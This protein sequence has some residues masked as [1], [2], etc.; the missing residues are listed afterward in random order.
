MAKKENFMSDSFPIFTYVDIPYVFIDEN[1]NSNSTILKKA[2]D[3]FNHYINFL[4]L[5]SKDD[6]ISI[7]LFKTL[8]IVSD[9]KLNKKISLSVNSILVSLLYNLNSLETDTNFDENKLIESLKEKNKKLKE[10]TTEEELKKEYPYLY[11]KSF[12]ESKNTI[13]TYIQLAKTK[14][15][16]IEIF[17]KMNRKQ[18]KKLKDYYKND[19][20]VLYL[21]DYYPY[22]EKLVLYT[23]N[24][25]KFTEAYSSFFERVINSIDLIRNHLK[26]YS[27]MI[28]D[29]S[30]E[31][32]L[33][34]ELLVAITIMKNS[35]LEN[36]IDDTKILYIKEF[37]KMNKDKY[38]KDFKVKI[39]EVINHNFV[40]AAKEITDVD[41]KYYTIE[42]LEKAYNDIVSKKPYLKQFENN[43][44]YKNNSK[45]EIKNM[46]YSQLEQLKNNYEEVTEEEI[47]NTLSD[48]I[49]NNKGDNNDLLKNKIASLIRKVDFLSG[50]NSTTIKPV[51]F[52]KGKGTFNNYFGYVYENGYVAFDYISKNVEK[53]YGHAIYII[54]LEDL[55]KYSNLS[56]DE[57]R[58]LHKDKV[59]RVV[60]RG[61]WEEKVHRYISSF[62]DIEQIIIPEEINR[63]DLVTTI[64]DFLKLKDDLELINEEIEKKLSEKREKLFEESKKI[65]EE[66]KSVQNETSS[67][68]YPSEVEELSDS[69]L[70]LL[71]LANGIDDFNKLYELSKNQ[72]RKVRRNPAVSLKTKLRTKDNNGFLHCDYCGSSETDTNLYGSNKSLKMFESHHIIPISE[73]GVDN[74]YNT[75]CL[76]P[77]CHTR[78]HNYLRLRK[79]LDSGKKDNFPDGTIGEY[80]TMSEYGQFL[81][82]VRNRIKNDTPEYLSK[83]DMLFYPN[84]RETSNLLDEELQKIYQLEE[85]YYKENK[86]QE[87]MKF[88][89]DWN[90]PK[91]R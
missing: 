29:I 59:I 20:N 39:R 80:I 37:L 62:D 12:L 41:Y 27:I 91:N 76:C 81:K 52:I 24:I 38:A 2:S 6:A 46:I 78:I 34:F 64:K 22:I 9:K 31:E 75:A 15:I 7:H 79:K 66:I 86:K 89:F 47:R 25:T 67:E 87:D 4:K 65:D 26:N 18:K 17:K 30:E 53:S 8:M 43:I 10:I 88:S 61:E 19:K 58:N 23:T 63:I 33:K 32:K 83:F 69:E 74:V 51:T 3:V 70:E 57:L 50:D 85:D 82:N 28:N 45:E 48:L 77:G 14:G 11:K 84:Y 5:I 54:K 71:S 21:L 55:T 73:G 60:H 36:H 16:N 35:I 40:K 42:D 49:E 90:T 44:D 72:K 56:L 68:L 13:Y 1:F